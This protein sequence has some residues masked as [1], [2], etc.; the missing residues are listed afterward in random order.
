MTELIR[1]FTK[2]SPV[3]LNQNSIHSFGIQTHPENYQSAR[4][5]NWE[6]LC[7]ANNAES[8]K[9]EML[10]FLQSK[11]SIT[12]LD[13]LGK[14]WNKII[15]SFFAIGNEINKEKA[16]QIIKE[17]KIESLFCEDK[18]I[19]INQ[20]T[21]IADTILSLSFHKNLGHK[22][23]IDYQSAIKV[24]AFTERCFDSKMQIPDLNIVEYF[25]KPILLPSCFFRIDPC[26]EVINSNTRV[27]FLAEQ[28][29]TRNNEN[30]KGCISGNCTCY[31]N[32][33]CVK[34]SKCCVKPRIDLI[35]LMV[36]KD[37]TKC[38]QAGDLSFIKNVLEGEILS[39]KHRRLERTEELIETESDIRQFEERY[40]QTEDKTS[41]HKETEDVLKQDKA[42]DA[43]LTTNSSI[44]A[45]FEV[46]KFGGGTNS[47]TNLSS[48][49]SKTQ[50]NKDVR[51]Y[52]KDVIDRATKQLEEKVRKLSSVK[53]I[54]ETEEK[55]KHV[56]DN[57]KGENVNGQ[58]LYVNKVSRAQV[59]NYGKTA[60]IDLILPEPSTLYKR[61]LEKKYTGVLPT[62]QDKI[63]IDPNAITPDNYKLLINQFGL[64]DVELPP[65]M[66]KDVVIH[67]NG[68]IEKKH[69]A[70]YNQRD[71]ISV[72]IPDDYVTNSMEW[73]ISSF[74]WNDDGKTSMG[75]TLGGLM[76]VYSWGGTSNSQIYLPALDG[77]QPIGFYVWGVR[78]YD[79]MLTV[80]CILKNE[81][82]IK[83]KMSVFEKITELNQT[84]LEKYEKAIAEYKK[85]KE[86]FDAKEAELKKERYNKNPFINRETEKAELKRMA[87]SYISCQFFDQFD[88]MKSKV[89]PCG[90][91]EM[92]IREAEQEAKF[93]Q[94]FEQAF[95]WNLLTYIFYPYFWGKKCSWGKN[96]KEES[97]D[98]IFEKFLQAGS[99]R[100]LI[101]IRNGFFDY[102]SYFITTGEIWGG[103]GTTPLPNDPHYVSLAQEIKEQNQNFNTE[104]LGRI[105]ATNGN[106]AVILNGTDYYWDNILN[107]I[108]TANVNADLDREILLDYKFYRIV[109]IVPN[110]AVMTHDSWII[111]LERNYEGV[112]QTNMMWS[113]GAVYIGAP[114]EFVTPTTL[115][116]LRDKSSCLPCY[117]LKEC[118]EL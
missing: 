42:I 15:P 70:E 106:I 24:M 45:E 71:G 104:R 60:V 58:Y 44:G 39:T 31:E 29:S 105:N 25:K 73:A 97:G 113:T 69:A 32:E 80:H 40:L 53:R 101:P 23:N 46:F 112:T 85:D 8:L 79:L 88:S 17:S 114:W 35:D 110:T 47:T 56:F 50:T 84:N 102:V 86:E 12:K 26:S 89:E 116:F 54:F 48:S 107:V 1:L 9:A 13:D 72:S 5:G 77:I 20:F 93:I 41:L 33:E 57:S 117:P 55:N 74:N 16:Y 90:Y 91:P 67:I 27:P 100:L 28:S 43:G 118:K 81:I 96:L 2:R 21:A 34:Q 11:D 4:F 49:Q 109:S 19:F 78:D 75:A 76:L 7:K 99:C 98:L 63:V 94:F 82:L 95:N 68:E 30:I 87:I 38:Y 36:V 62:K 65:E 52:S 22:D 92:N 108:N 83:W 115:T 61:L 51:D 66:S 103:T 10:K 3:I 111:T 59:Y 64:K 18:V 37:Y 14:K 6:T